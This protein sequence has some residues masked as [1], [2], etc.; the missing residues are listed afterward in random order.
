MKDKL[1]FLPDGSLG[2]LL[3][4]IDMQNVYLEKQPWGCRDTTGVW[5]R[6][7]DLL[8][9]KIAD[10]VI[11]TQYL[12]PTHPVGTWKLYNEENK[13]INDNPWMSELIDSVKPYAEQYLLFSKDKYSSYAN[14]TVRDLASKAK[15]VILTGVV[16]ECCVLFTLL[17]G[18]DAGDKMIYLTDACT[19][20]DQDKED[21]VKELALYYQP[22]HT[23]VM[24]CEEYCREKSGDYS[25]NK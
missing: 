2:D 9:H 12:P 11:F 20:L 24:T 7:Q 10:N 15:R 23:Q 5:K 22:M 3:M 25:I 13:Q 18:I 16:A 17:S 19:G 6:I 14:D 4:V 1:H 8:D 21:M